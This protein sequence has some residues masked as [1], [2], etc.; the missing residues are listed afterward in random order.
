M[1]SWSERSGQ[2]PE[3]A[4]SWKTISGKPLTST[5][6]SWAQS[7]EPGRT[8]PFG[9]KSVHEGT[10]AAV[11]TADLVDSTTRGVVDEEVEET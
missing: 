6:T 2:S 5:T 3:S 9:S 10:A 1:P 4:R 7:V 11:L 8:V